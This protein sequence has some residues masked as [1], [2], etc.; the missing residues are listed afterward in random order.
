[1]NISFISILLFII[2]TIFYFKALKAKPSIEIF[3]NSENYNNYLNKNMT[4]LLLYF[5][6]IIISQLL[7]NIIFITQK[8]KT[9]IKDNILSAI[10]FTIIP[11]VFI[12]GVLIFILLLF[13]GFKTA[14][15]DVVGY[16]I[17]YNKASSILTELLLFDNDIQ[18]TINNSKEI[19][20]ENKKDITKITETILKI[21]G[22]KGILINKFNPSNFNEMWNYL[23]PLINPQINEETKLIKQNEFLQ[24]VILR[25]DIG[26]AFW[27]VYSAILIISIV[28]YNLAK[29][30]C[31][32]SID[33]IKN[34]YNNYILNQEEIDKQNEIN[35]TTI[36]SI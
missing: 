30:T 27:Y 22:N 28:Y 20:E 21:S 35:N 31:I 32:K 29:N 18:N 2:I 11:W 8:C 24:L 10:L 26:E 13:P 6:Y 25:D 14:F 19:T 17:V 23:K 1:M 7:L 3:N 4:A 5:I 12:F 15:S 34:N 36:Y 33:D 9:N 16:I